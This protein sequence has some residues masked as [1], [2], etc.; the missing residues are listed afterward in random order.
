DGHGPPRVSAGSRGPYVYPHD[1][2]GAYVEQQY[3]PDGVGG[4]FYEPSDRGVEARLRA[5]LDGLH[6]PMSR[7][8]V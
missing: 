2:D 5:H 3:L 1:H 6:R 4:G 8:M 7:R